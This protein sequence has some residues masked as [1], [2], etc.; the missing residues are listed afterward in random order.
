MHHDEVTVFERSES[1]PAK[2]R[3]DVRGVDAEP[4]SGELR[5][6]FPTVRVDEYMIG[7]PSDRRSGVRIGMWCASC[8]KRSLLTIAHHEGQTLLSGG[9]FLNVAELREA[10]RPWVQVPRLREVP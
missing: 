7:N 1:A 9:E 5:T 6:R 8:G 3:V 10:Q 2:L 4:V